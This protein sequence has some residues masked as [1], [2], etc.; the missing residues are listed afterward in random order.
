MASAKNEA[1]ILFK[2]ETAEFESSLKSAQSEMSSLRAEM[3]LAEATFKATGDAAEYQKSKT[4]ILESQLEVNAQKQEALTQKLEAAKAIYGEDSEEA[5]NPAYAAHGGRV[6]VSGKILL[7]SALLSFGRTAP[8]VP[9]R[10]PGQHGPD[11]SVKERGRKC[12]R[13]ASGH[14]ALCRQT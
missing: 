1:K 9:F 8:C 10:K 7:P 5:R 13:D 14:Y 11:I 2:A 4:E 6:A 3:K 12:A